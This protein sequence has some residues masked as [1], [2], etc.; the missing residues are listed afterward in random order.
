MDDEIPVQ[1]AS[2]KGSAAIEG[3]GK[4]GLQGDGYNSDTGQHRKGARSR[5]A[6]VPTQ[7]FGEQDSPDAERPQFEADA[8]GIPRASKEVLGT[9]S[10]GSGVFL[11]IGGNNN[12]RGDK[13]IHRE[14]KR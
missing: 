12:R 5:A 10:M 4:T 3:A 9:T 1:G 8:R 7:A 6:F 13:G 11:R 14:S 2:G